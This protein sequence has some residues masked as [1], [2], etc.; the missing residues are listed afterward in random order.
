MSDRY[1]EIEV[2]GSCQAM[3]LQIG[4]AARDEIRGFVT[5]SY[6]RIAQ[7]ICVPYSIINAVVAQSTNLAAAYAPDL[8]QE[9]DG[10]SE[11]SGVSRDD[12]MF[13][14]IRN[15]LTADMDS[16]CTSFSL[17]KPAESDLQRLSSLIGQNWDNDPE[18][19]RY[20]VVLTRRPI[21]KPSFIS[22]TQAGLVAYIGMNEA[23]IAACLNSLPAPSRPT[24]VPHYFTLRRI[25]ECVGLSESVC[26]VSAAHRAIPANIMMATPQGPANLEVTINDVK[27]L[28][29]EM[30]EILIH[31]NHCLHPELA[32]INSR[33]EELIQSRPRLMRISQLFHELGIDR[34]EDGLTLGRLKATL[35][36]HEGYP[37]SICRHTN[38]LSAHGHWKTVFSVIMEPQDRRLHISRGNPCEN[39]FEIYRF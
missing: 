10:I 19:D 27:V 26:A 31:T 12:L 38:D 20:T 4:E 21:G 11:S 18:L 5:A 17:R 14:Q 22:V 15:Q 7:T 37:Q 6:D 2:A 3:G 8:L 28:L 39:G 34:N 16:G 25:F 23:G 35:A 36:D 29:P 24:G 9:L 32:C 1:R 13:L 33:F 30:N